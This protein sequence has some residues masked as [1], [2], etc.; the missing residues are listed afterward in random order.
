LKKH[1]VINKKYVKLYKN[2]PKFKPKSCYVIGC[3]YYGRNRS[4]HLKLGVLMELGDK[5]ST[6][7]LK[8]GT[9]VKVKN[10]TLKSAQIGK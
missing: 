9:K 7:K 4:N 5:T 3:V 10:I 8:D 6:L 1:T 2:Q